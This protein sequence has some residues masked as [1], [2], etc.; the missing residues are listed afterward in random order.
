MNLVR[1]LCLISAWSF[2]LT[3]P[4][5]MIHGQV[6]E[7]AR[8]EHPFQDKPLTH[9]DPSPEAIAL[10]RYLQDMF[11]K[12]ILSGQM[13]APWGVNEI[14]YVQGTTGKKPAVA[15]FDLIHE[16][17]NAGEVQKA[18]D[19]WNDGGI[20]T[21][22]WHWGAPGVGE[23]YENSKV[24]I[25]I[26]KCF[27]EGTA[28]YIAMWD[29]LETKADH[30]QTLRD[31]DVP[32]LWRPFHELNGG[33]FWWGMQG[34]ELFRQLWVTMYDY[35]VHDRGLNNLIW[36][37]CYPGNP[38][39]DWYPGDAYVDIAGADT[40]SGG[41]SSHAA[42]FN[43]VGQIISHNP[44]PVTYHECGVP[45]DPDACLDDGAMWSWWMQ[46]HTD[47]L[48]DTDGEYLT[49]VYNHELV[50]TLDEV[51]DIMSA[52]GWDGLCSAD[53]VSMTY[54]TAPGDWK[55]GDR[56]PVYIG[57]E[58]NVH[59]EAAGEGSWAWSGCGTGGTSP[60]QLISRD[61]SCSSLA[62]FT[63]GCGATSSGVFHVTGTCSPTPIDPYLQVEGESWQLTDTVTIDPGTIVVLA[64]QPANGGTWAWTGDGFTADTRFISV[65]P[66][67]SVQYTAVY[68][69][70]CGAVSE[71]TFNV[72]VRSAGSF[73]AEGDAVPF[74]VFPSPFSRTLHI[75]LSGSA[76]NPGGKI[77]L[78]S[79]EG[80]LVCQDIISDPEY[81]F[82]G[83]DLDRGIYFLKCILADRTFV[84]PI[85]KL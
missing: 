38:D 71:H 68:T 22:M 76:Q 48:T 65:S 29:E 85:I 42:M 83:Q 70:R 84:K 14:D 56:I 81:D 36:V 2:I 23:G 27:E 24:Q 28:E 19:Y 33:W 54:S 78:F 47:F 53:S 30:L 34:P 25:D 10:F 74:R 61:Q 63:N 62:V 15:G 44:M 4:W 45:P 58:V 41:S 49:M 72:Y 82:N 17:R 64:P 67:K 11:G 40:Y 79:A 26:N 75:R 52:Y 50:V 60:D 43:A 51:P 8:D 7:S 20:P 21:I 37:L 73:V 32:V 59:A 66:T 9:P 6:T 77:E 12:R 18:I 55:A 57:R 46:W 31:A 3:G 5:V 69:N 16:Y 35:F 80:R 13:W 39:P 1:T